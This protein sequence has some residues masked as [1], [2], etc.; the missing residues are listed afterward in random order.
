M[1]YSNISPT[2][3]DF[4]EIRGFPETKKKLPFGGPGRVGLQAQSVVGESPSGAST[5]QDQSDVKC[6]GFCNTTTFL[7]KYSKWDY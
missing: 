6:V 7:R 1:E 2:Y 3:I 4:P 5:L